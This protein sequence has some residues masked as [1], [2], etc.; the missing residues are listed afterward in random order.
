MRAKKEDF[1]IPLR[2]Y[3]CL[4]RVFLTLNLA[5]PQILRGISTL[6]WAI[7]GY[8]IAHNA[9]VNFPGFEYGLRLSFYVNFNENLTNINAYNS[10]IGGLGAFIRI[11]NRSYLSYDQVSGVGI[12]PGHATNIYV[13]RSFRSTLPRPYSQCIIDNKTNDGFQSELFNLIQMS[14]YRY[15]QPICHIACLQKV[16]LTECNCTDPGRIR[17]LFEQK[18]AVSQCQTPSEIA[19]MLLVYKE[20]INKNDFLEKTCQPQCPIEC[21]LDKFDV[22][23]SSVR[24]IPNAFN[25][26]LSSNLNLSDDFS[27]I[28]TNKFESISRAS[29]SFVY[30]G[31]SYRELAYE[32]STE[33]PQTDLIWLFVGLA[34]YLGLFMGVSV[35]SLFEIC[36]VFIEI[37]SI[38]FTS[39]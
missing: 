38:Y 29:E 27:V 22:T 6:I 24:L 33:S 10:F 21:Y 13:S 37:F 16:I 8:T 15:T 36:Q 32:M 9:Q 39:N 2:I 23:L 14:E 5:R 34:S 18:Y 20:K 30:I 17:S 25:D 19:C 26:Y 28:S 3:L 1:P 7:V 35:F 4:G 31:I 11:E 12:E